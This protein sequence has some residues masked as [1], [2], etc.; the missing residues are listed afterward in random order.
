MSTWD[1]CITRGVPGWMFPAGY[2]N[3]YQIVQ[4]PGYVVIHAEMI[5][6]ARII[7]MDGRPHLRATHAPVEG[8]SRG[9]WE[10]DTLVV[11]TTDFSDKGWIATSAAA[12]AHQGHAAE[13]RA[14][15]SSS[16]SRATVADTIDYEATIEDP[17]DLHAAVDT[18]RSR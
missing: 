15:A 3:A 6:D 12:G 11:E 16:D 4:T 1:R 5:H 9:R 14:A 2:N 18:W 7:P 13:R 17:E 10:G 8:D